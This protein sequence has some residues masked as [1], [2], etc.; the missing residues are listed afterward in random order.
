M[1]NSPP[2]EPIKGIK[3]GKYELLEKIG[4]G[5]MA[6]IYLARG[7]GA[8][9]LHKTLVI[10]RILPQFSTN[11]RFVEM[12]IAEAKIAVQLNHPN[13]VQIYDFGKVDDDFYLAMEFVDG[14][15][16]AELL[17]MCSRAA[18]PLP[19][20][21]AIYIAAE[22]ARGLHYAHQR[23][24]EFGQPLAI[25]H[26]DISP[27]NILVST[28]GTV[29]IVDFGI[30]KATSVADDKPDVVK[31]KFSYMS[32][33]QVSAHPVDARSD[34][35]ST[36]VVLFEL[37]SG[38]QLFKGATRDETVSLVK[39]GI[40]PDISAIN[41][42][43]PAPLERLL[44]KVL[45]QNPAERHQSAR[46]FQLDLTRALYGMG[47]IHDAMTL[48]GHIAEVIERAPLGSSTRSDTSAGTAV[49]GV[50]SVT[51]ARSLTTHAPLGGRVLSTVST[52]I[53]DILHAEGITS[54]AEYT[55]SGEYLPQRRL[56][57]PATI[58]E[59]KE[60]VII[61]GELIGLQEPESS[62]FDPG[63]RAQLMQDYIR[64][65][66][67]IAYKNDG[68]VHRVNER[69]FVLVLGLPVSSE[70]DAERAVRVARDLHEA[71][72]GMEF[73]QESPLQLAIGVSVGE[74]VLERNTA[75]PAEF[76]WSFYQEAELQAVALAES[77][78]AR[79]V[80]LGEQIYRRVRRTYRCEG[81]DPAAYRAQSGEDV[82]L[83]A[84]R[85]IGRKSMRAQLAQLRN[86]DGAFHGRDL[87]LESLRAFYRQSVL[88]GRGRGVLLT[89]E[90]GVGK[91]ALVEE[92][93][94]G[95]AA[96]DVIVVRGV[97]TPFE[98]DVP[99]SAIAN[100]LTEMLGLDTRGNLRALKKNLNAHLSE[101][102]SEEAEAE[103][104]LL[105]HSIGAI[106]NI[107]YPGGAF[108]K[109]SAEERRAR[110]YLS[111]NRL[112]ERVAS[113]K[114]VV[115]AIEDVQN[116]DESS[117]AY[118]GQFLNSTR[119]AP[120]FFIATANLSH[121]N[122]T[123]PAW[124]AFAQ[125]RYLHTEHLEELSASRARAMIAGLLSLRGA[126]SGEALV[127]QIYQRSGG[128]PL[129]IREIVEALNDQ[130]LL[131]DRRALAQLQSDEEAAGWLPTS[132]EG[133]IGARIDRL[134]L[135][136]KVA[137]QRV[138]L[139]GAPFS[140]SQAELLLEQAALD[141]LE[142]LVELKFLVRADLNQ[143][144]DQHT[145]RPDSVAASARAYRFRN[146]L[147]R[148]VAARSLV[149]E[150]RQALHLRIAESLLEQRQASGQPDASGADHAVI[151]E[152]FQQA[153]EAERAIAHYLQAASDALE[154]HGAAETLR[155]CAKLLAIAP[156]DSRAQLDGLM[157]REQALREHGEP[158]QRREALRAL[159]RLVMQSGS[160]AEQVDVLLRE[161]RFFFDEGDF[162]AARQHIERARQLAESVDDQPSFTQM[163]LAD[164]L[165]LEVMIL[166]REGQ[167]A[168]AQQLL[169]E[170]IE[171]YQRHEGRQALLGLAR[172]FNIRGILMRQSGRFDQA[173]AAYE[174]ALK[175]AEAGDFGK[176]MR[177]LLI[178]TGVALAHA[179]EFEEAISRYHRALKQARSLG[180]RA[181]EASTLVNLGHAYLLSGQRRRASKTV[182]RGIRLASKLGENDALADGQIA[183]GIGY[184]EQ[185]KNAKAERALREGL[186]LAESVPNVY[187]SIHALLSLA[188]L[189]L[190]EGRP[191]AETQA[192]SDSRR[193]QKA[194]VALVQAQDALERSE[195]AQMRWEMAAAYSLMARALRVLGRVD[196]ALEKSSTALKLV[197]KSDGTYGSEGIWYFHAQ[198]LE[199]VTS[200]E[201]E[202]RQVITQARDHV[203]HRRDLLN[204]PAAREQF[205]A[206]PLNRKIM[207]SAAAILGATSA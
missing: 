48:A 167:R 4:T 84:Y 127:E 106:F 50:I 14:F 163:T 85:L 113:Q 174:Q 124:Q 132:L 72:S 206:R 100:L 155:L 165:R 75:R 196:E 68:V 11:A 36:G 6:E 56:A 19:V 31:G 8:E 44:Y 145:P 186:R 134:E 147:T 76:H 13:I 184:L 27:Q 159:D 146:A 198:L 16:L 70:N 18:H 98:R 57:G 1:K 128:N 188:A 173:I 53:D 166:M 95:L 52:P 161:S 82:E 115:A 3:F 141:A 112:L 149:P 207:A 77:A 139:L 175:Y 140:V 114:P 162:S 194:Q 90:Q 87:E 47:D 189:Q 176:E 104:E 89:G 94:S 169:D 187:L 164:C 10:K 205:M 156:A 81:I 200:R 15:N 199:G 43:V 143:Q 88:S 29:K 33:E 42:A 181:D 133:L 109:L 120:A 73:S 30:A 55:G 101:L 192:A 150:Q 38:R 66:E 17:E 123:S 108:Q 26:R 193:R 204:D 59:R 80:L 180:H 45:A 79:E 135:A 107:R 91:S 122:Q 152:H 69:G 64:I 111:I 40:V 71:M 62:L 151:G 116:L 22:V 54:S 168:Q 83:D 25:V 131:K 171:I 126:S 138:A 34:L 58:Q 5:G 157:L 32:P 130:G 97:I 117:L 190:A 51:P 177:L 110:Q 183:L 201:E 63:R 182:R 93:L 121:V 144:S 105:L 65:I 86:S 92:F 129:F 67:A 46:D 102:F 191:S 179:G 35:F 178:N 125:A 172:A 78:M 118:A 21:E 148:E 39:S 185:G 137:L 203:T 197:S 154:H 142:S 195:A 24:D 20:G 23:L 12:F 202:R 158:A 2:T 7:L 160:L 153:G 28:D 96:R 103:R 9:G 99:L 60:V 74:S 61:A 136:D 119:R 49:T 41:P 37:L 170:A